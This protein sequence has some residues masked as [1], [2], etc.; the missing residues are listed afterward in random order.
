[1]SKRVV[2]VLVSFLITGAGCT[3]SPVEPPRQQSS[4]ITKV[5]PVVEVKNP[6]VVPAAPTVVAENVV[7]DAGSSKVDPVDMLSLSHDTPNIDHLERAKQL[8][9]E[10][11]SKGA[12]LEA[13]RALFTNGIDEEALTLI[14]KI[15]RDTKQYSMAAEAWSRIARI[16]PDDATP[17]IQASRN[18]YQSA[19]FTGAIDAAREALIRDSESA[20]AHHLIGLSQLSM[21]DLK[22]SIESFERAIEINP[23]HAWALN[24]VGLAYLR[25]NENEK[26]VNVLEKAATLLP[27]VAFVQNNYGVALERTGNFD[28]ARSAF[29]HAMDLSP[30][31][32]K[33]RLNAQ[34]VAK[35]SIDT[36]IMI[37]GDSGSMTD[38][39]QSHPMPE[40]PPTE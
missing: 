23:N 4:P 2:G 18:M 33:A 32:V 25:A 22:R 3:Q 27:T 40:A 28:E 30:K 5:V 34:R 31:Y 7:V 21:K 10:G 14:S 15:A 13:R 19:D 16:R 38:I 17:C 12:L 39:P 8:R 26:A 29:Q 35:M 1:M 20:E 37:D 24:N 36:T 9:S 6:V 11:N